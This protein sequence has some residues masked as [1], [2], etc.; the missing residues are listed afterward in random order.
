MIDSGSSNKVSDFEVQGNKLVAT[1]LAN[2]ATF[3][4][5]AGYDTGSM[6]GV[7]K[8]TL[9]LNGHG[10]VALAFRMLRVYQ[11]IQVNLLSNGEVKAVRKTSDGDINL[12]S[13]Y[14]IPNFDADQGWEI[15][16]H[17]RGPNIE[18]F[19]E[20]QPAFNFVEDSGYSYTVHGIKGPVGV[21]V[22]NLFV[23]DTSS[24]PL[25]GSAPQL[26]VSGEAYTKVNVGQ[27]IPE[28]EGT[29]VDSKD[30]VLPVT[31][32]GTIPTNEVE[33]IYTLKFS[34]VD[35]DYN[36]TVV[37]R[38]VEYVAK[39]IL[40]F[41]GGRTHY[42]ISQGQPFKPPVVVYNEVEG[43]Q[44]QVAPTGW[45][46]ANRNI[47]GS[48]ELTYSHTGQNGETSDPIVV[49]V[50]VVARPEITDT[51]PFS[52]VQE[53]GAER[54]TVDGYE[55][56]RY[57]SPDGESWSYGFE[58]DVVVHGSDINKISNQTTNTVEVARVKIPFD[59]L[60]RCVSSTVR[61]DIKV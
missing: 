20:G 9:Y 53:Y 58:N 17:M 1:E 5:G 25:I 48:Y 16:A 3:G 38:V 30:G 61:I 46:D 36:E 47:I 39:P 19:V 6:H 26:T 33:G 34:A 2:A 59:S 21:A 18:V 23:G 35:S 41:N 45:D 8:G 22:D 11:C 54:I 51:G 10:A 28:F 49:T 56:K 55:L 32:E 57:D 7:V 24:L 43:Y 15:E 60:A 27:P 50:D 29:A 52:M 44:G 31:V 4:A 37:T 42:T 12:T 13:G 14:T 40:E